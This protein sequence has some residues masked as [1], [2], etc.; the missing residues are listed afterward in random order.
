MAR[1]LFVR[2]DSSRSIGA[3]HV[4]RC[5]AIAQKFNQLQVDVVFISR[6]NL[7]DQLTVLRAAG[8]A[9]I[10]LPVANQYQ[11][12][13]CAHAGWLGASREDDAAATIAAIK[14]YSQAES[15]WLLVD[16]FAIDAK[17]HRLVKKATQ[18]K[19]IVIDGLGDR[20]LECDVLVDTTLR[21]NGENF[22]RAKLPLASK[23]FLGPQQVLL[24]DEFY[25]NE[26]LNG[27]RQVE[28]KQSGYR[29]LIAFG[30]SDADNATGISL[31]ALL[32]AAQQVSIEVQI[33][34]VVGAAYPFWQELKQKVASADNIRLHRQISNVA[35]LMRQADLA[36]GAGGT[37]AW[38]RIALRL[39]SI[40][41]AI[42]ENQLEQAA[43][44]AERNCI[45]YLGEL[46]ALGH[47][48][49]TLRVSE[50]LSAPNLWG[51]QQEQMRDLMPALAT[52][53]WFEHVIRTM[54]TTT[55]D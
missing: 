14:Q 12:D 17:W 55:D 24:R 5:L 38:E 7:G 8:F 3:G 32:D 15:H 23:I 11:A 40:V 10:E 29:I 47:E 27:A 6:P 51:Q 22:W 42:A 44:L 41:I 18:A 48:Q 39:P 52:P 20:A 36:I 9:V 43:Q 21:P 49:L 16:H 31:A 1:L 45:F 19:I 54:A 28:A 13:W 30:G 34:I 2:V 4:M 46:G 26:A 50:V 33:D 35:T 37:M 25:G 53:A